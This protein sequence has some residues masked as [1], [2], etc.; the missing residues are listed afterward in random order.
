M[1]IGHETSKDD[2][3][4]REIGHAQGFLSDLSLVP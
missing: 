3:R 1:N 2:G 4:I